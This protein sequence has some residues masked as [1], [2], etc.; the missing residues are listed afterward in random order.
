MVNKEPPPRE[1]R[2]FAS[3]LLEQ[4]RGHSHREL[5]EAL[6][7]L[8]AR[9]KDTGKKGSVTYT[10]SVEPMKGSTDAV[11]TSDQIKTKLPEHDRVASIFYIDPTGDLVRNDPNQLSLFGGS[12]DLAEAP[13]RAQEVVGDE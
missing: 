10:L 12:S 6:H 1:P 13:A 9:V 3:V 5:S 11:V 8:V 4:G 7:D 2:D